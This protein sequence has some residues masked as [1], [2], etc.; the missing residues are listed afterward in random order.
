M[1]CGSQLSEPRRLLLRLLTA[2]V[3]CHA[4]LCSRR[5]AVVRDRTPLAMATAAATQPRSEMISCAWLELQVKV[6]VGS[7]GSVFK[8]LDR[9]DGSTVAV[10]TLHANKYLEQ[11]RREIRIL[12]GC[13]HPNIIACKGVFQNT[14]Q[15]WIVM[16]VSWPAPAGQRTRAHSPLTL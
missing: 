8:A 1:L 10:K 3:S 12:R 16:E 2:A 9:R 7:Y 6:G 5:A 14:D 13:D 11:L 4:T 15:V